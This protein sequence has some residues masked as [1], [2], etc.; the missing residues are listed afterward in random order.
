MRTI[1]LIIVFLASF[2]S[3]QG[4][5]PELKINIGHSDDINKVCFSPNNRYIASCSADKTIRLWD[6][7]SGKELKTFYD[8]DEV[9]SVSFS[10]DGKYLISGGRA[11]A[12]LWEIETGKFTQISTTETQ[13]AEITDDNKY[14][15]AASSIDG[16]LALFPLMQDTKKKLLL[17]HTGYL[18]CAKIS[19][20]GKYLASGGDDKTIKLWN[21]SSGSLIKT[22]IGH[23][24]GIDAIN[25]TPDSKYIIS[26]GQTDDKTIKIWDISSGKLVKSLTGHSNSVTSI[27]TTPDGKQIISACYDGAIK[28]W[29]FETGKNTKTYPEQF[30]EDVFSIGLSSTGK[31]LVSGNSNKTI[32][33]IDLETDKNIALL[34][35]DKAEMGQAFF[36]PDGKS[37]IN[38]SRDLTVNENGV[39]NRNIR[40]WNWDGSEKI[41]KDDLFEELEKRVNDSWGDIERVSFSDNYENAVCLYSTGG[42]SKIEILN[43]INGSSTIPFEIKD[44]STGT[45]HIAFSTNRKVLALG[46]YNYNVKIWRFDNNLTLQSTIASHKSSLDAIA[47]SPDGSLLATG[48]EDMYPL[49]TVKLWSTETGKKI[50]TFTGHTNSI[51][52]VSF[53][54]DGKYIASA[55]SDGNIKIYD[56]AKKTVSKTILGGRSMI[57]TVNF[58]SDGKFIISGHYWNEY[59]IKIWDFSSGKLVN[60]LSGHLGKVV[61]ARFSADGKH[62]V[63]SSDDGSVKIWDAITG[64]CLVS[65]YDVPNSND[66]VAVST[67]GRFDGTDG[68]MKLLYYVK[69]LEVIPLESFYEKFFTPGLVAQIMNGNI[70]TSTNQLAMGKEIAMPPFVKIVSPISSSKFQTEQ[71]EVVIEAT[72]MGGGIDEIRLYLNGKLVSEEQRGMKITIKKGETITKKYNISL[73]SGNNVLKATAF[74]TDRTESTPQTINIELVSAIK[75]SNLYLVSI[76]IDKYKNE[77]YNL[78]YGSADA[79]GFTNL[80]ALKS[81]GIFNNINSQTIKDEEFTKAGILS[82]LEELSNEIRSEDVFIFYYA[83][84]GVMSDGSDSK[85]SEFFFIPYDVTQLYGNNE[86]L[87]AKG[88]SANELRKAFVKIKAQKQLIVVDACQ[89]G[90]AT[91]MLA[92]R[93]A[94]EEKALMQLARSAGIAVLSSTGTEQLASEVKQL[95]HGIFTYSLIE[96]LNGKADGGEKD[97]KI[98]VKELAA[99]L[100]DNVPELTKKYRGTTQYPNTSIRGMD[101]PIVVWK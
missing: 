101:F 55:S 17:G 52:S 68:G 81:K 2:T 97:G 13:F 60:T 93:G 21:I 87:E 39:S 22:F 100:E 62:V 30:L 76:G 48:G 25:F 20:N 46:E 50:A 49:M 90:G 70:E 67:D 45:G 41:K 47:L 28:F 10:K 53:S 42:V 86:H 78:S 36:S 98:T 31:Y 38:F 82:K 7:D 66:W 92:M 58:S 29:D 27:C 40:H 84:H 71:A 6:F 72:D 80:I 18:F 43:L 88:I 5:T 15:A 63:S 34:P 64:K 91:E 24:D 14:I 51:N 75:N 12:R 11:G 73:L 79:E 16:K 77:K 54:P 74:N 19:P 37:A 9:Y 26:G 61:S 4:Q 83:G 35:G 69:D 57:S 89:S 65:R 94:A 56:V 23:K 32:R 59:D 44:N 1:S 85:P 99:F 3:S 33:I 95:G 8:S 96:G